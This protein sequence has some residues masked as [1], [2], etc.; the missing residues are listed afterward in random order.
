M[1]VLYVSAEVAPYAK[2][3]GLGDVAAALPPML[4]QLGID[5]RIMM[6]DY[7]CCAES[8]LRSEHSAAQALI[9]VGPQLY[10]TH[11]HTAEHQG[12]PLMLLRSCEFF[13]RAGIYGE[14][15]TAYADN[16][17]RF[18]LF[19]RALLRLLPQTGFQP[20]LIHINDWHGALI[21][22]LLRRE[23][24]GIPFFSSIK[25]LLTIHNLAYNGFFEQGLAK[26]L[27]LAPKLAGPEYLGFNNGISLLRGGIIDADRVATVSPTHALE[28]CSPPHGHGL[29]STLRSRGDAIIGILNGID[30]HTWNPQGDPHLAACYEPDDL[31]GKPRCKKALQNELGLETQEVQP[32]FGMVTRLDHQKGLDLVIKALPKLITQG[33]QL[34]VL[35]EGDS[36][37]GDDLRRQALGYPGRVAVVQRFDEPLAHRIYAGSDLFLMP[38]RYEPCGLAQQI[39]L[40]YGSVPLVHQT[41]GLADT[42]FDADVN[43]HQGNGFSFGEP[44]HE[45]LLSTLTRALACYRQ[46]DRWRALMLRGMRG[47]PSWS[48]GAKHYRELYAEIAGEQP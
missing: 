26:R 34:V 12:V 8:G 46:P 28:I 15:G 10:E 20:D 41:G 42:V 19:C 44:D 1:K 35:G 2:T 3:G 30:T 13:M 37:L 31:G 40:R 18:G 43:P 7:P 27:D 25:T 38:S 36:K 4:R 32:L 16:G 14:R 47:D 23:L 22:T 33:A 45:A 29:D 11:L 17:E 5:I 6:P 24:S 48:S 39:A 9:P 21:P